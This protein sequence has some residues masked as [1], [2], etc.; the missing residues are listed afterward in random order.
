ML[1]LTTDPTQVIQLSEDLTILVVRMP[2]GTVKLDLIAPLAVR[3]PN[4]DCGQAIHP[5]FRESSAA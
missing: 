5:T 1:L 3:D 2:N 4:D